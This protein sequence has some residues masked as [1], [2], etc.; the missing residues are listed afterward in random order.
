MKLTPRLKTIA[1]LVPKGH[2][3]ADVGTDH[4]YIP[5]YLIEHDISERIIATD[6]NKGPLNNAD[7]TIQENSMTN[8]IE[9]RLGGGL[10]P[11]EPGEVDTVIVAGMGGLLIADIMKASKA[12]ID[13]V[14]RLILQPM[15]AQKELRKWLIENNFVIVDEVLSKEGNKMYEIIVVQKGQMRDKGGLYNEI[16]YLFGQNNDP[17]YPEFIDLKINK[18]RLIYE[19]VKSQTSEKSIGKAKECLKTLEALEAIRNAC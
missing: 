15:V 5:V 10:S 8:M 6:I 4:A 19:N 11:Y 18:Y 9:T 1:D 3:V 13:S 7:R 16:G 17:L 14:D 12:V 2:R